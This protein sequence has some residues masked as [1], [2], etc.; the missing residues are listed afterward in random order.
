[1][2]CTKETL[3]ETLERDGVAVIPGVL[4]DCD[5]MVSGMWDY[6]EHVSQKWEKPIKR[7]DESTW[8]EFY[9][10]YPKHSML[11]QHYDVGHAQS[12]WDV[13]QNPKIVEIFQHFWGR[14]DLLVS[15]DGFSFHLPPEIT[16]KGWF[17][18]SWYHSDQSFTKPDFQCVQ[19]FVTGVDIEEGDATLSVFKGSHKYHAEFRDAFGITDKSD[20]TLL[21]PEQQTFYKCEI[22]NI[23]CPKGSLVLWDSRTIHCGI[24]AKKTRKN[25]KIRAII[26]LCYMPRDITP[27]Q[28]KKK[29]TAFI[30]RRTTNH[31]PCQIKLFSKKPHTY[32]GT[33]TVCEPIGDLVLTELGMK[34]A[35]F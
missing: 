21:T 17:R 10:L 8:R 15:F 35:G 4:D 33:E 12:S 20:W 6:L 19:S 27:A 30:E 28:L 29:Q 2:F 18:K 31:Y 5:A 14:E 22:V 11:L 1:M 23:V 7:D 34:L 32:G 9:K 25:P 24:E 26:Y 13:R 3:R 16:N